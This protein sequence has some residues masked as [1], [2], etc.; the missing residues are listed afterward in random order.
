[1]MSL[2]SFT[3]RKSRCDRDGHVED[4]RR[5]TSCSALLGEACRDMVTQS[6]VAKWQ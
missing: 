4:L 5:L 2:V 6:G 1:M 3:Q